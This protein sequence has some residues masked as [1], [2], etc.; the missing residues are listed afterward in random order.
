[1]KAKDL[2]ALLMKNPE[3]EV[4]YNSGSA[5]MYTVDIPCTRV[6]LNDQTN[7]KEE[8]VVLSMAVP[9]KE[10]SETY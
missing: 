9:S 4:V 3:H 2:A 10:Y 7:V 8:V 1:M 5:Y 6:L